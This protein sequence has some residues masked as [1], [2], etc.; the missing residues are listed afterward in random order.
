MLIA[1]LT[2]FLLTLLKTGVDVVAAEVY[3]AH[4]TPKHSVILLLAWGFMINFFKL[5]EGLAMAMD[6]PL[7]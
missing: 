6:Q 4:S 1:S 3:C 5:E 2:P 7:Q